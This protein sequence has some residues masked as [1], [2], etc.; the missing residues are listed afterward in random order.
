MMGAVGN[1]GGPLLVMMR[2]R[3]RLVQICCLIFDGGI[4]SL[5]HRTPTPWFHS[6]TD[7]ARPSVSQIIQ[8]SVCD[9]YSFRW[10]PLFFGRLSCP[11]FPKTIVKK[12]QYGYTKG[13][14]KR[15]I[16]MEVGDATMPKICVRINNV[17][18]IFMPAQ[19]NHQ[20][21]MHRF[22]E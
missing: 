14:R 9:A 10:N 3:T 21:S 18:Q 19:Q 17:F 2:K 8:K 16:R 7:H 20:F 11:K 1:T 5:F 15:G 12:E 13:W 6:L 22:H 4:A